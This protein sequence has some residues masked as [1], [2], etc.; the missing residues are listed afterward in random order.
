[1]SCFIQNCQSRIGDASV[2]HSKAEKVASHERILHV[3]ARRFRE[4][5]F[6]GL[7]LDDLMHEAGL[8]HGGFYKHFAS[9]DSL[10][11]EAT[12]HAFAEGKARLAKDLANASKTGL[13]AY[14]EV[15]LTETH[16]A[17]V[18]HGCP[19]AALATDVAR[20]PPA[21]E[22]FGPSFRAYADWVG[23]MLTG[24]EHLKSAR[25]AAI[26]CAV[27]GTIAI[28]RGLDDKSFSRAMLEAAREL[29]L[30]GGQDK[31]KRGRTKMK[32]R[33][34]GPSTGGVRSHA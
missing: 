26:I 18:G 25:G 20:V 13:A 28:A 24:P 8:T 27:A 11:R 33:K 6:A 15:Y 5:G 10:V 30:A 23:S 19:V 3:A 29:I 32:K 7:S 4:R 34:S 1:M 9:R 16:R 22:S 17:D 12:S 31:H 2:G 21:R 14:L